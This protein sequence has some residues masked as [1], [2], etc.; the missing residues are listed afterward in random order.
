MTTIAFNSYSI[1][2]D[3]LIT[4][5]N[6]RVGFTTKIHK[7]GGALC[8]FC[9]SSAQAQKFFDWVRTGMKGRC[10]DIS[11]DSE[12]VILTWDRRIHFEEKGPVSFPPSFG[13]IGSGSRFALGAMSAGALPREAVEIASLFDLFTGG[14]VDF[15]ML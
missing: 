4:E 9:G 14:D 11:E 12:G 15:L 3:R 8:G 1:A 10:P 2:A 13:A 7:I 6:S 5:Y